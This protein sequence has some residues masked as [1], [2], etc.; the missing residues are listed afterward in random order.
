MDLASD[1]MPQ[2]DIICRMMAWKRAEL[3]KI[4]HDWEAARKALDC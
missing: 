1:D 2:A 3:V 4:C